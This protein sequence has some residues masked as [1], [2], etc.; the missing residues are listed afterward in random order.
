[1][2]LLCIAHQSVGVTALWSLVAPG[3]GFEAARGAT[4]DCWVVTMTTLITNEY[5]SSMWSTRKRYRF[6]GVFVTGGTGGFLLWKSPVRQVARVFRR[7][8]FLFVFL[9]WYSTMSN[10]FIINITLS[11]EFWIYMF[12]SEWRLC[13]RLWHCGLSLWQP[14]R[15]RRLSDRYNDDVIPS[16]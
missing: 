10:I 16:V 6:R 11:S 5:N 12:M 2:S 7:E 14:A 9:H 3:S 1:M 13:R 15:R 4:G 8:Y